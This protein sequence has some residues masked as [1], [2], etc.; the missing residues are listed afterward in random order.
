MVPKRRAISNTRPI[1]NKGGRFQT[2]QKHV[3]NI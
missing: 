1:S 2:V 3:A